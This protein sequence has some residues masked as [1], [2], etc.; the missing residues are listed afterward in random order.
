[1]E[2]FAAEGRAAALLDIAARAGVGAG[3]V[4]RH[5]P[6]KERLFSAVVSA[7]LDALVDGIEGLPPDELGA[8]LPA[9]WRHAVDCA[10]ENA[11]LCEVLVETGG[12]LTVDASTRQRYEQATAELVAEAH[13]SG[14]LRCDLTTRDVL[15]LLSAAASAETRPHDAAGGR[16]AELIGLS[17]TPDRA[18]AKPR[19]RRSPDGT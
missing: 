9:F 19:S 15:A 10:R 1:M 12:A 6:T 5:F 17:M 16:L 14:S 13:L 18:V 2:V 11:D 4:Y 3:T 7:R 8:R